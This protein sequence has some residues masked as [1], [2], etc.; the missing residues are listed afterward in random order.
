[1]LPW[2]LCGRVDRTACW[3]SI[4]CVGSYGMSSE[5]QPI[6]PIPD[7]AEP[8]RAPPP[9]EAA[10]PDQEGGSRA[11]SAVQ[12][13]VGAAAAAAGAVANTAASSARQGECPRY[14]AY[15]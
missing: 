2:A 7:G 10:E 4:V 14:A 13:A 15:V 5:I 3:H 8:Y 6:Q 9:A 1:M 12:G 11:L